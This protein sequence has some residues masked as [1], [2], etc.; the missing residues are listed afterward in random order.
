MS[1]HTKGRL[2]AVHNTQDNAWDIFADDTDEPLA[3]LTDTFINQTEANARRL[4]ACWNAL[5]GVDTDFIERVTQ[6]PGATII[7]HLQR[8][9]DELIAVLRA[10]TDAALKYDSSIAGAAT[11]GE[12]DLMQ[13][14]GGVAVS[15]DLDD[16]YAYWQEKTI[17]A[18]DLLVKYSQ[19][20]TG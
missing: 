9:R 19:K 10:L 2:G 1:E 15:D 5:L 18:R 4:V 12:V 3:I 14:G 16:L 7:E 8:D 6:S 17:A 20:V 11:R 13:D